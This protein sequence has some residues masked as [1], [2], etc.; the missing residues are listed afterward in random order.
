MKFQFYI[1]H[2]P[3]FFWT[4]RGL[5]DETVR[6][7]FFLVRNPCLAI[8]GCYYF[9]EIVKQSMAMR[10]RTYLANSNSPIESAAFDW[11]SFNGRR[12]N[13][14]RS[15][16]RSTEKTVLSICLRFEIQGKLNFCSEDHALVTL[17]I[18]H[19]LSFGQ[20]VGQ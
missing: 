15:A 18:F 8:F 1:I 19:Y 7:V 16:Y 4:N 17:F 13:S 11:I 3:A 6:L 10:R 2:L 14:R 20:I 9:L 12:C 5:V